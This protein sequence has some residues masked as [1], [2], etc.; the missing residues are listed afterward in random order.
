[1]EG[2]GLIQPLVE[3]AELGLGHAG[4]CEIV[5]EFL[6]HDFSGNRCRLRRALGADKSGV[7]DRARSDKGCK[8]AE[9]AGGE[10][11]DL[12]VDAE[13]DGCEREKASPTD[14]DDG[15]GLLVMRA[16]CEPCRYTDGVGFEMAA[17]DAQCR[18]VTKH[19]NVRARVRLAFP[20]TFRGDEFG[21]G[22]GG[23]GRL[24]LAEFT[25]KRT[26]AGARQSRRTR[27]RLQ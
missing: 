20:I 2:L 11:G 6:Q 25:T 12:V 13:V 22:R 3:V 5:A 4:S 7:L 14:E 15:C 23:S 21:S 26:Y 17:P 24:P 27:A 16:G 18:T 8:I 19:E 1:M 10:D 9:P